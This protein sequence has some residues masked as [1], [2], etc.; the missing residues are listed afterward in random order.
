MV[1]FFWIPGTHFTLMVF[2]YIA[3]SKQLDWDGMKSLVSFL[4]MI[5]YVNMLLLTTKIMYYFPAPHN[6]SADP[7]ADACFIFLEIQWI[8]FLGTILANMLFIMLRTCIRHKIQLDQVP[9]RKQLPQIDTIVAIKEVS[10]AFCQQVV[11]FI[12]SGFLFYQKN[13]TN[14]EKIEF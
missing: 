9:E 1:R 12:T 5:I 4:S 14:R 6:W 3:N 8:V 10:D 11:P 2:N 7:N 13:G